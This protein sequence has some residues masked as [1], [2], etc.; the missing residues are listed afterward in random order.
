MVCRLV[1]I[2]AR[3]S[4]PDRSDVVP[5]CPFFRDGAVALADFLAETAS[6]DTAID[7]SV[8]SAESAACGAAEKFVWLLERTRSITQG[9]VSILLMVT[10]RRPERLKS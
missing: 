3:S 2:K 1:R 8:V 9:D 4:D 5:A 7:V 10:G 6:P